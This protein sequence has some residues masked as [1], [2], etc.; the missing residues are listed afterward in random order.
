MTAGLDTTNNVS[1]YS[2]RLHTVT[3]TVYFWYSLL[4]LIGRALCLALCAARIH[5][6]SLKPLRVLHA[7]PRSSWCPE[8]MRFSDHVSNELMALSGMRFF[9]FTRKLILSVSM[10]IQLKQQRQ[11]IESTTSLQSI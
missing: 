2:M 10:C 5:D 4:F 8:V 9:Y 7:I 3:H 11:M 1:L 6:E